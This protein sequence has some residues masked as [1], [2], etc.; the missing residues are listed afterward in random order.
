LVA[1]FNQIPTTV[2]VAVEP[3]HDSWFTDEVRV[4]LT[5]HDVALCLADVASRPVGPRWKTAGWTFLRLHSGR[6]QPHPCYGRT[7]L[8]SWSRRLAVEWSDGQVS[9]F[10]NN[11][12][13]GCAVRDARQFARLARADSWDPTRVP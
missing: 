9:V 10:F 12:T 5:E 8:R 13:N 6:A 4:L 1:V 11:D 3:R 2:R 7:A